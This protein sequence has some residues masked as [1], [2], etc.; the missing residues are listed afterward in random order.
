MARAM[1]RRIPAQGRVT[2]SL[3]R[4]TVRGGDRGRTGPAPAGRRRRRTAPRAAS[5][6]ATAP[7]QGL[8]GGGG[9]AAAAGGA[10]LRL[11]LGPAAVGCA[12]GRSCGT[13]RSGCCVGTEGA[14]GC[15]AARPPQTLSTLRPS[16]LPPSHGA[17]TRGGARGHECVQPQPP[18]SPAA[19][20]FAG[21]ACP[22]RPAG[23]I[24]IQHKA[25]RTPRPWRREDPRV[26][27]RAR[28]VLC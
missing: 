1:A 12:T 19:P 2:V 7:P 22:C 27:P 11:G 25:A 3:R 23:A 28:G 21:S 24:A 26:F 20:R 9:I 13:R 4:S 8:P 17:R 5:M 18:G 15:P 6:A 16:P 10:G 14:P